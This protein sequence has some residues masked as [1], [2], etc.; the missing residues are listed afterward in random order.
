MKKIIIISTLSMFIHISTTFAQSFFIE[1]NSAYTYVMDGRD[2]YSSFGAVPINI[3]IGGGLRKLQIGGD[4]T[5][6]L[7][8][9]THIY[10]D[11]F[12]DTK[13]VREEVNETYYGGFLQFT[14]GSFVLK[15]GAGV[16]RAKKEI[17]ALPNETLHEDA[18]YESSIYYQSEIGFSI[19]L[20]NPVYLN[21][22]Y[23][24]G[25]ASRELFFDDIVLE[26]FKQ[27]RH[28]GVLGVKVNIAP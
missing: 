18:E 5:T 13:R 9:Q 16:L 6:S 4:Y 14:S 10:Y 24:I 25:Y 1:A 22:R 17:Y 27:L 15:G 2:N 19:R 11:Q 28:S 7:V 8:P 21:I 23:G 26:D 3:A 20:F 12:I